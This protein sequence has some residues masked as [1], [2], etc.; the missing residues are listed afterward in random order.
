MEIVDHNPLSGLGEKR[1]EY[2][3]YLRIGEMM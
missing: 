1:P 2:A 3:S